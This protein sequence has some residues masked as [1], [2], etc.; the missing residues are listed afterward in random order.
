MVKHLSW[1][2]SNIGLSVVEAMMCGT[3]V[4]AFKR[5]SMPELILDRK[6]GFL[7]NNIDEALD[8]VDHIK[9]INREDCKE[10]AASNFSQQRMVDAYLE[11]YKKILDK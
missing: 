6:T 11:V 7:V 10:W 1:R 5:G 8:V 3:P 4:I 2:F 9:N